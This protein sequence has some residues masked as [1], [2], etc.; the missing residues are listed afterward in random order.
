MM[1]DAGSAAS[2][3]EAFIHTKIVDAMVMVEAARSSPSTLDLL[4]ARQEIDVQKLMRS[5]KIQVVAQDRC[6]ALILSLQC[7]L[8]KHIFLSLQI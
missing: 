7:I 1:V 5:G 8:T 2:Q 3:D 6:G 4:H